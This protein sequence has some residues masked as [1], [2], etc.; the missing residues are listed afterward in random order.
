[1]TPPHANLGG[2]SEGDP[3]G[4]GK[5]AEQMTRI[6]RGEDEPSYLRPHCSNQLT[7]EGYEPMEPATGEEAVDCMRRRS[8]T[9][10]L[11]DPHLPGISGTN[12][13]WRMHELAPVVRSTW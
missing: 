8:S 7:R 6:P 12:S 9:L 1:M 10:V 2:G 5:E 11:L 4:T 13:A 3:D